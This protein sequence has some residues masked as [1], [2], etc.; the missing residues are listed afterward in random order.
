[1]MM[2]GW[3]GMM[4]KTLMLMRL[5]LSLK[6]L[7]STQ[8]L[9]VSQN[10]MGLTKIDYKSA[11]FHCMLEK[12]YAADHTSGYAYIDAVMATTTPLTPFMLKDWVQAMVST[13]YFL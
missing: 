7:V 2:M 11:H 5:V 8:S 10:T 3:E 4:A 13:L 9:S 6:G 1:M 12:K